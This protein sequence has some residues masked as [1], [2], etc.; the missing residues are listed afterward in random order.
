MDGTYIYWVIDLISTASLWVFNQ[1]ANIWQKCGGGSYLSYIIIAVTIS[2]VAGVVW[3]SN[4]RSY[5]EIERFEM[6]GKYDK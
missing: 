4:A 3:G 2:A 6:K 1:I 5:K